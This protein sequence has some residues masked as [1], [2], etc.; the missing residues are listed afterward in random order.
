MQYEAY[1]KQSYGDVTI[2]LI[3]PKQYEP[4]FNPFGDIPTYSDDRK[5]RLKERMKCKNSLEELNQHFFS[6]VGKYGNNIFILKSKD[7]SNLILF[8][9]NGKYITTLERFYTGKGES[10]YEI[11][12]E[13]IIEERK[14]NV[15]NMII[16]EKASLDNFR[17]KTAE[18]VKNVEYASLGR[19]DGLNKR[20]SHVTRVF[21]IPKGVLMIDTS[22]FKVKI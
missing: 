19:I 12:E 8:T 10:G 11:N 6:V 16:R 4:Y 13:K 5:F 3:R 1:Y 15:D 22:M 14:K 9:E 2:Y 18:N 20:K 21:D 7:D 17:N